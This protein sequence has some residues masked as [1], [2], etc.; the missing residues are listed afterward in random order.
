[1]IVS[2]RGYLV[3]VEKAAVWDDEKEQLIEIGGY[4]ALISWEGGRGKRP[5]G[6]YKPRDYKFD[7]VPVIVTQYD[8]G[9]PAQFATVEEAVKGAKEYFEV[10][11][12]G[13][14]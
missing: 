6:T 5:D 10:R 7:S 9:E 8:G 11:V 1:M 13:R 12:L 4:F 3:H 2:C 14:V